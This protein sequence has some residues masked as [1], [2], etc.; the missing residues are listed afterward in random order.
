MENPTTI[1]RP[2]SQFSLGLKE[3][4]QYRE[5]FYFFTWKE[6]KVRYKQTVLG[7]LWAVLQP[8]GMMLIFTFLFSRLWKIETGPLSYSIFV[9]GG[10]ICWNLFNNSV[11]H[12]AESM[13]K[14]TSIITR[15]YF[16]RLIIPGSSVL[17]AL[18][19][20]FMGL[21]VFFV[22]C[23]VYKQPISLNAIFYFPAGI[24]L[25][26]LSAFGTGTL[27]AALNIKFRD[28]RYTIPFL[29]QILFFA[30]QVIYPLQS[31]QKT[32]L[33]YLLAVNPVNAAIEVFRAPLSNSAIDTNIVW[34][35]IASTLFILIIGILYFRKTEAYFA[36]LA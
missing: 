6:I 26:T 31:I 20:F 34:I 35:G 28:F 8:L 5:L 33:K 30:S 22:F 23:M 7:L 16:P 12:A 32:E 11:S 19:D 29:L 36:D 18:F 25:I 14:N 1:I 21:I 24:I 15:I 13:I 27:L 10:L 2:P 3:L 9:L 17:I 4:W